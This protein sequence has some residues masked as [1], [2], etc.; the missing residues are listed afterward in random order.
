MNVDNKNHRYF[1]IYIV[2]SQIFKITL[3]NLNISK[4]Q[5]TCFFIPYIYTIMMDIAYIKLVNKIKS[6]HREI[7]YLPS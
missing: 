1:Y 7:S 6:I 3:R 5:N 4:K 2:S